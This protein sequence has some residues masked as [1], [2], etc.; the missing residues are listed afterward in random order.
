M[1]KINFTDLSGR[2]AVVIGATS[3]IGRELAVGLAEA[4]ADVIPTGRRAAMLDEV[5]AAIRDAGVRTLQITCD[6][7]SRG[8]INAL[9]DTVVKEFGRVDTLVNAA[10]VTVK[11]PTLDVLEEEWNRIMDVNLTGML[12]ASQSFF[13]VLSKHRRGRIIN[14]ASLGA[15]A[16]L[17]QVAAYNSSKAG[18]LALTKSLAIE[19]A[20]EGG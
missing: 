6:V 17:F 2:I 4:G 16:S 15:F 3:G 10:G 20:K 12:R 11:R 7:R 9:R 5:C 8:E 13:P 19:W 14:I 1:P 18:V